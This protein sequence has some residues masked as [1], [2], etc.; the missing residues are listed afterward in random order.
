MIAINSL[1]TPSL[2]SE[3]SG[4]ANLIRGIFGMF[5][6]PTAHEPRIHWA[7]GKEDAEDLLTILSLI[8]RRLDTAKAITIARK[9]SFL[10]N[11]CAH[12]I[13]GLVLVMGICILRVS[14][15]TLMM[16]INAWNT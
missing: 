4:F 11:I 16:N 10:M 15:F 12:T 7:M 1:A 8:H 13:Y 14:N 3:Q 9:F 6:N 5:R 2:R